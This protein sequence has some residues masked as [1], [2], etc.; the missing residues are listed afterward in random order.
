MSSDIRSYPL[1]E[2]ASGPGFSGVDWGTR[3]E[4]SRR[5]FIVGITGEGGMLLTEQFRP[6]DGCAV[7]GLPSFQV[8]LV[9]SA[10]EDLSEA[11]ASRLREEF[12]YEAREIIP[13]KVPGGSSAS[14]EPFFLAPLLSPADR[15]TRSNGNRGLHEVFLPA[16][17]GYLK[18]R[19]REGAIVEPG[20]H[21]GVLLAEEVFPRWARQQLGSAIRQLKQRESADRA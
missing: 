1:T 9:L 18:I 13:I 14:A 8:G 15:G 12:G 10:L 3:V 5:A 17:R 16:V 4:K 20:L 7:V 6:R 21:E 11:A 2:R 19:L